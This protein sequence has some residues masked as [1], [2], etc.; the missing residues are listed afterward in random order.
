MPSSLCEEEFE[1]FF[2]FFSLTVISFM[3]AIVFH[4]F[5]FGLFLIPLTVLEWLRMKCLLSA[6]EQEGF[7]PHGVS[8]IFD[9]IV[10]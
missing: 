1:E 2:F 8:W 4:L 7:R 3:L 10:T 6:S 9:Y 5:T